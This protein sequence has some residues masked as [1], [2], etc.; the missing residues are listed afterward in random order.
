MIDQRRICQEEETFGDSLPKKESNI[1]RI[2][3]MNIGGFSLHKNK[4]KEE[5]IC[6]SLAPI[7]QIFLLDLYLFT[8]N[9]VLPFWREGTTDVTE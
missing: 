2:G 7:V 5:I 1:L 9:T 6:A 3:F 8:L 4:H